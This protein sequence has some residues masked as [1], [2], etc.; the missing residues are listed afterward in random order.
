MSG[1][2]EGGEFGYGWW[3]VERFGSTASEAVSFLPALAVC[4]AV[5][6]FHNIPGRHRS[7]V[8]VLGGFVRPLMAKW[9]NALVG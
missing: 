4:A 5:S 1:V 6:V 8:V 7:V 3:E 9:P 2:L